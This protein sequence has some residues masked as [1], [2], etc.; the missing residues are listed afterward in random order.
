[1][2]SVKTRRFFALMEIACPVATKRR[3]KPTTCVVCNHAERGRI[4]AL[5]AGGA[6]LESLARKFKLSKDSVWRHWKDHVS[7]DLKMQYLAGPSTVAELME[8][9][10]AEGGSVLDHLTIVRSVLMGAFTASAEAQS[11]HTLAALSGR[12]VEVLR[13]IGRLT[14][15]IEKLNPSVNVTTNVAFVGDQRI[16]IELQ[17]GLLAIA[18]SHP[19]ARQD[20]ISLLRRLD[21]R[22]ATAKPNGG[23]P[24][25][26]E[27]QA[28]HVGDVQ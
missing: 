21:D 9:A 18:R 14:G 15:E 5:R 8:R 27:A 1:L 2:A 24:P 3:L 22:P 16:I 12:L 13:E 17:S 19:A 26:L 6:S 25:M 4:E 10:R 20:I 7:S 11:A 28:I 23:Q